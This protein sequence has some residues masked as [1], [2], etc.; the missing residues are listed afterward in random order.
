VAAARK[1]EE[2][3][4]RAKA[5]AVAAAWAA[6]EETL[7]QFGNLKIDEKLDT[8]QSADETAAAAEQAASAAGA[9]THPLPSAT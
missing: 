8:A 1:A 6:E 5:A 4:D 7:D 3:E 9:H 2:A